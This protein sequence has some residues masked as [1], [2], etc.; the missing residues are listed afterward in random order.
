[1]LSVQKSI[2]RPGWLPFPGID[3][4]LSLPEGAPAIRHLH[5][6]G[7][8]LLLDATELR[9]AVVDEDRLTDLHKQSQYML[10]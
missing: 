3:A 9:H 5:L 6:E 10:H 2:D 4:E 7:V 1:M 8:G